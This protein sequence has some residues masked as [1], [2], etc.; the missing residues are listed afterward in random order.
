MSDAHARHR[1]D[2]AR[3]RR[4]GAAAAVR[5]GPFLL[6]AIAVAVLL[7]PS[8]AG[9]HVAL[10]HDIHLQQLPWRVTE[11]PD[12]P[13][14]LELR[15]P[16]DQYFPVQAELLGAVRAGEDATWL[17]DVGWGHL[18]VEFVG[19]GALSPFNAPALALPFDLAWSWS[20]ALRLYAAMVGAYLLVR[21]LGAGRVGGTVA[22]LSYG[23][24]GFMVG[25]L[26]WPQSHVG[27]FLP[28]VLWAVRVVTVRDDQPWWGLPGLALAVAGLWLGGF[29][30]VSVYALVAAG[31]VALHGLVSVRHLGRTAM[32]ARA[33]ASAGGVVLGTVLVAFTLLPSFAWL[34]VMDLSARERALDAR[35]FPAYLWTFLFPG[36]FGDGVHHARWLS[37]AYV[38]SIGYAG[39]VT[40][41]LAL[42]AWV[43][44]RPRAGGD[45]GDGGGG[46]RP[47]GL[48]LF[49]LLGV[50]FGLLA[51]GFPPLVAVVAR[52]PP[53][54]TNA[55]SRTV[56]LVGLSIAV[57]GGIGA[58]AVQRWIAG[59]RRL[60]PTALVLLGVGIVALVAYAL[61]GPVPELRA[62]A[63]ERLDPAGFAQAR[64]AALLAVLRAG[65]LVAAAGAIVGV[66]RWRTR[67]RYR[68]AGTATAVTGVALC[69]LV[70]VDLLA[71]AWG[72][73]VQVPRDELFPGGRG[74]A[75]LASFAE[76]HRTAGADGAGH[77][78]ATLRYDIADL[79]AHAFLTRRQ[80]E[81]L[82]DMG[83]EFS[84]PTR[85]DLDTEDA[86]RW[87]PW[88]SA[89]AV[90]AV[91]VPADSGPPPDGWRAEDHGPVALWRNPTA[92]ERVTA[93][94]TG[95]RL[96]GG[97]VPAA[98]AESGANALDEVAFVETATPM[99]LPDGREAEI[100]EWEADGSRVR[101]RVRSDGGAVVVST[102]A[103]VPGWQGTVDGEPASVVTVDYL[104]LGVV[105]PPGEHL[106]ELRYRAPGA[107]PGRWL[108][109]FGA[110]LLLVSTI[111]VWRGD[112]R[113]PDRPAPDRA[114]HG[115]HAA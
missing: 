24:S 44:R 111:L 110:V 62:T 28:W 100:I 36:V 89:S 90:A 101:A 70:A 7:G 57:C 64:R 33:A 47:A 92:R 41:A 25:W 32:A 95:R 61:T 106:V 2:G 29:P 115:R 68:D 87:E 16:V 49:T 72:W 3:L 80:R 104:L 56:V 39:V 107:L 93:V 22:G 113:D 60:D 84:S 42:A 14:N 23:L 51:Y 55:P 9:S 31:V 46:T 112:R 5:A 12:P 13:R 48:G 26:G 94:P 97:D 54:A 81:V 27:A 102:D 40:A 91:I 98:R 38:E 34:D 8:L 76:D 85:W 1:A 6:F 108:S 15:D 71:F 77:P 20:Q 96:E 43:L 74:L 99:P 4:V 21:G 10:A 67:R 88:L 109:G 83:A 103:A 19:Y 35:I 11:A 45:D 69:T 30:A 79:R 52:V 50:G 58:D 63:A 82:R 86:T 53:L 65:A 18:G 66:A 105:V 114:D 37:S 75:E 73:N 78:N 59:H 17:R